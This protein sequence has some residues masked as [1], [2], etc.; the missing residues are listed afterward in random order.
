M[1][2][3]KQVP[4]DLS[5]AKEVWA[6]V[7][8]I[9]IN[10]FTAVLDLGKRSLGPDTPSIIEYRV[11]MPLAQVKAISLMGLRL[12]R[13]Y[14][15]QAGVTISLPPKLLEALGIPLDDWQGGIK[16]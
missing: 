2:Q 11:R 5:Q 3:I 4:P 6:D 10:D 1:T 12:I 15:S 16:G 13:T 14:E 7:F 9:S 8:S